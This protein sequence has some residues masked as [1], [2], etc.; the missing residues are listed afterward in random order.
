MNMPWL[1]FGT[2]YGTLLNFR[3]E[4]DALRARM[5]EP[6]Y[7]A[8]PGAPVL[9]IKTANTWTPHGR[10]IELPATV[11]QVEVGA[12]IAMVMSDAS[13]VAGHVLMNDLSL[14]HDGASGGFFRPPVKHRCLDG[15][16]GIGPALRDA[17]QAHDPSRFTL[18]VRINDAV[19]QRV[20]FSGLLRDAGTLLRE[21][22][23]F[24][25]LRAG[26]VLMLGCD[27]GRPMARAGDRIDIAAPGFATLSNTLVQEG[28]A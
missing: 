15:F 14:P 22:S 17:G 19:R 18:E 12:T 16:L 10:A 24:M 1:P 11:Q 2:V 9:Y 27:T 28:R 7:K 21:V 3:A 25:T 26:D 20:D 5:D 13:T 6:P 4:H 8:A 23:D